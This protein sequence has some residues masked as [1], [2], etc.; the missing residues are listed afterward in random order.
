MPASGASVF[1]SRAP[2]RA[3][4]PSFVSPR[5]VKR[6]SPGMTQVEESG[7]EVTGD[8]LSPPPPT[9]ESIQAVGTARESRNP[10]DRDRK[11]CNPMLELVFEFVQGLLHRPADDEAIGLPRVEGVVERRMGEVR[12]REPSEHILFPPSD[13]VHHSPLQSLDSLTFERGCRN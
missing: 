13:S 9:D 2:V 7:H 4:T 8:R 1:R 6:W 12:C 3:T 11:V 10:L 5:A